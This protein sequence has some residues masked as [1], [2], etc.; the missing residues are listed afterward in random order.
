MK[1]LVYKKPYEVAVEEV[2]DPV[3]EHPRDAIVKVTTTAICGSDLHMYA[4][5]V[6]IEPGTVFGHEIM[7]VIEETGKDVYAFKKGDRVVLPFNIAC[8]M[9]RNCIRGFTNACLFTNP[10]K[11]TAG[12]GYANMG[13]YR[14]GQAEYVRVPFADFNALKLPGIPGDEYED[15]F[16]LLADIFPTGFHATEL[17]MVKTG[18]P[19][20]IY[21]AGPVG[22]LAAYSAILKGASDVF[23]VDFVE[24]RLE[25][26][27]SIGAI[28]INFMKGNPVQQIASLRQ[29]NTLLQESMRLG[30]AKMSWLLSGI[31][32]V[33]YEA[34]T[35]K[36]PQQNPMQ[37]LDQLVEL[38][39]YTGHIGP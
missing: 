24:D 20:V 15:D 29:Q 26:A 37:I 7:G 36:P 1:A 23:I 8:G 16:V 19:V 9:C 35:D 32:A 6:G 25:K 30:E 34:F 14:G 11:P 39:D 10:D 21:G 33:G 4:G 31:D 22:L 5:R 17:A 13:P 27:K 3:I 12:Y 2:S 18:S 28:P 38:L